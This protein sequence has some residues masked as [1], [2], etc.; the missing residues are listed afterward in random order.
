MKIYSKEHAFHPSS[1][2]DSYGFYPSF[3][4]LNS[5][6]ATFLC[7]LALLWAEVNRRR[8]VLPTEKC[9]FSLKSNFSTGY[10]TN[11][12]EKLTKTDLENCLWGESM[13]NFLSSV[14]NSFF[15][16]APSRERQK[17][18]ASI[19]PCLLNTCACSCRLSLP[20]IPQAAAF[21]G[22]NCWVQGSSRGL[23]RE[24]RR[25]A[26]EAISAVT[27]QQFSNQHFTEKWIMSEHIQVALTMRGYS[28]LAVIPK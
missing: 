24:P 21:T 18:A 9:S 22:S 3:S 28:L 2:S 1:D 15:S 27:T 10:A 12:N 13:Q 6:A 17:P 8:H 11:Q 19:T 23:Y 14:P 7:L 16:H 20:D 26:A 5:G 25:G 4:I